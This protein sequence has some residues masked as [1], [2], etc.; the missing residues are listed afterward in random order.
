MDDPYLEWDCKSSLCVREGRI[1]RSRRGVREKKR[2]RKTEKNQT[3]Q[4]KRSGERNV[5]R[6]EESERDKY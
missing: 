1:V 2:W 5:E 4:A 3:S 6:Q